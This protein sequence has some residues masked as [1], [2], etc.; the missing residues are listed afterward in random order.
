MKDIIGLT[1]DVRFGSSPELITIPVLILKQIGNGYLAKTAAEKYCSVHYDFC[2]NLYTKDIF[3]NK[4]EAMRI[5]EITRDR[6][7]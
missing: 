1:V 7:S 6:K 5:A 2:G 4:T 3:D